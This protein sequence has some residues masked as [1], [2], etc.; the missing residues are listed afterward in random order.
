MGNKTEFEK[1]VWFVA[2]EVRPAGYSNESCVNMTNAVDAHC[3]AGTPPYACS[4]VAYHHT[5]LADVLQPQQSLPRLLQTVGHE[6]SPCMAEIV[7]CMLA[8]LHAV[9][10][11][12]LHPDTLC[13]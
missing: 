8:L 13:L 4:S 9:A 7:T 10:P 1:G 5:L 11:K 2:D 3:T 12:Y 6:Q